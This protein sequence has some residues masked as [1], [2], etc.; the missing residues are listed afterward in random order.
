MSNIIYTSL[1]MGGGK[2]YK[3]INSWQIQN[4]YHLNKYCKSHNI[5]LSIVDNSNKNM[6]ALYDNVSLISNINKLNWYIGTFCSYVSVLDFVDSGYE[7]MIWADLD[8]SFINYKN[9]L[10]EKLSSPIHMKKLDV[11][12]NNLKPFLQRQYDFIKSLNIEVKSLHNSSLFKFDKF[13]AINFIEFIKTKNVDIFNLNDLYKICKNFD[14]TGFFV[15]DQCF[16]DAYFQIF[17]CSNINEY[18]NYY[19]GIKTD[20]EKIIHFPGDNKHLIEGFYDLF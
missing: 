12:L 14:H 20:H 5:A 17:P 16:Y 6:R 8:M 4:L 10:F 7:N 11:D 2:D 1:Y 3:S 9:N 18:I 13:N 19:L 15:S